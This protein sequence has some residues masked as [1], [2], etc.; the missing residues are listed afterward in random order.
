MY[1][2][3]G[4]YKEMVLFFILLIVMKSLDVPGFVLG[5]RC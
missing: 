2:Y 3:V 4:I 1:S 5:F